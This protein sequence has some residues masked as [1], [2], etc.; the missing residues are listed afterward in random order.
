VIAHP[1]LET[2][3]L[4]AR[5]GGARA[6]T[7]VSISVGPE[8]VVAV[9]GQNGAGKSTLLRSISRLHRASSGRI[10]VFGEAIHGARASEVARR[11][12][13]FVREGAPVFADLTIHQNLSLASTLAH[14]RR[15]PILPPDNAYEWFP[16]LGRRKGLR[17]GVLSGGQRQMLAIGT[18][19]LSGP[20]VLL[21]DEPSAGLAP[22]MAH[23][24]FEAIRALCSGGLAVLIAEQNSDWVSGFAQRTYVLETGKLVTSELVD[25]RIMS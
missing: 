4:T 3:S 5:Y 13:S 21:L 1:A 14:H 20:S 2:E 6:L 9:L 23:T 19:L 15:M 7:D 24:V 25:D 8:E 11:G 22:T 18:A 12:L 10:S 17:A 16:E